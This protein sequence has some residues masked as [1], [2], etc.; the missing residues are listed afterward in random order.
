[1]FSVTSVISVVK[2]WI[3]RAATDLGEWAQVPRY[4]G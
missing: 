2:H 1:M 4:A 3:F